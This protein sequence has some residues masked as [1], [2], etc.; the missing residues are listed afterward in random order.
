VAIANLQTKTAPETRYFQVVAGRD[1][2]EGMFPISVWLGYSFL[3]SDQV[4]S[5]VSVPIYPGARVNAVKLEVTTAFAGTTAVVVGDGSAANG[6][7]AT[8]VITPTTLN[9]FGGDY[10]AAYA[11]KGKKYTTGDTIDVTFTGVATAGAGI[12]WVNVI[13]YAE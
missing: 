7:I 6:W 12:L 1:P 11:V 13:S 2:L 10:D 4:A 9:D 5:V 8:G 3:Y